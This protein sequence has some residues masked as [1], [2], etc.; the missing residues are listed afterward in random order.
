MAIEAPHD[1]EAEE[2]VLGA[3]LFDGSLFQKLDLDRDDFYRPRDRYVFDAFSE[4]AR[5]GEAIDEIT[6]G[7][8]LRRKEKLDD[9]GGVEF[10]SKLIMDAPVSV[11]V[12]HWAE[13]IKNTSRHRQLAAA[14]DMIREL[15]IKVSPDFGDNYSKA[16]EVLL[17]LK[18]EKQE[19]LESVYDIT[20]RYQAEFENWVDGGF[21]PRG[22]L[23]G[24]SDID[25][26][27]GGL[28]PG[29]LTLLA[30]R[31]SIGKTAFML[32]CADNCAQEGLGSAFFSLEMSKVELVERL[33]F[34]RARVEPQSL[35]GEEKTKVN[36]EKLKDK[37]KD[38]MALPMW[39][40]DTASLKVRQAQSRLIRQIARDDIDIMWFDHLSLAGDEAKNEVQ[41]IGIISKGLK[42]V[43][44]IC[45][46]PVVVAC[47]LNR[48]MKGRDNKRPILTDLR[49]S[50]NLEQDA[51]IVLG[52][53]RDEYYNPNTKDKDVMEIGFL[54]NR[55]GKAN[56][57]FKVKQ[58][59]Y[60]EVATGFMGDL[61]GG[62]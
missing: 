31:P 43:A 34:A 28:R 32:R 12:D 3:V 44:K 26:S 1:I 39:I 53:Y 4:L 55:G 50:G 7:T 52:L 23:I 9:I 46:I 51:D 11:L 18:S 59:I 33:V 16:I 37:Y 54:K 5:R 36:T 45:D 25:R 15:G 49:D 48:D 62:E 61:K 35:R 19:G 2:A 60:Y 24:F 20:N 42:A 58:A 27:L 22:V 40:D 30:A 56:P 38:V 17:A 10:L 21:Q 41:R 6:V 57:N 47:Q 29:T 13:I 14:G 8:E